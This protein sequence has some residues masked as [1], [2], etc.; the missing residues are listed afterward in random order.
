MTYE[1]RREYLCAIRDRYGKATKRSKGLILDEF[2]RSTGY[3]RKYAI[4][5]LS[6]VVEPRT[7]KPGPKPRYAK[8]VVCLKELWEVLDRPC[9]K[10]LKAAIPELLPFYKSAHLTT[11]IERQ[12]R[13]VSPATIDRLLKPYRT[14]SRRGLSGTKPLSYMKT[15]IPLELLNGKVTKPGYLEGDTVGHCGTSLAGKFVNTLTVTDIA[16]AWTVNRAMWCKTAAGVH[17]RLKEIEA[18]LPFPI[19]SFASDNGSELLN[20]ELYDFWRKGRVKPV[21]MVR[22]RPY[23]KNDNAHVEQKNHTHVRQLFG[24]ERLDDIAM[25][26]MMNEIYSAYWNKLHNF[27]IPSM[28]LIK[29]ERVGGKI[30]K[31]YDQ[32]KT[33]YE[34]LIENPE[35]PL[36]VKSRLKEQ[37]KCYNPFTLKKMLDEK[38]KQFMRL[39][40]NAVTRQKHL[41]ITA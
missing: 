25:V 16:S 26:G 38:M 18:E 17:E 9:S 31:R 8:V 37:K 28:K 34:R 13:D 41:P 21:K 12:L 15:T 6:G 39:V 2:T 1:A 32:P 29:R 24:Y 14:D 4:R 20:H 30:K 33:P 23:Q 27:F 7:R 40:E 5:I 3:S 10:K 11:E 36:W 19:Y 22:R 35:V